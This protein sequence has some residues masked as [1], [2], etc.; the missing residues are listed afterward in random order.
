M[1][2][3]VGGAQLA[4]FPDFRLP[5]LP[6][7]VLGRNRNR[8]IRFVNSIGQKIYILVARRMEHFFTAHCL[9]N[10]EQDVISHLVYMVCLPL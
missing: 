8:Y 4:R 2:D 9:V 10:I 1:K 7:V 5:V 3:E 6:E